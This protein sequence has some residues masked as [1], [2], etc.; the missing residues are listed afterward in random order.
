[1]Y[2]R[3]AFAVAAHLEPDILLVDEVL[4]VGDAAFQEKCLGK[5][6]EVSRGGR[7]VVFV[8]HNMSTVSALCHRA[9]VLQGGEVSFNG[10]TDEAI[11]CYTL[12]SPASTQP[13]VDLRKRTAERYGPRQF[14]SWQSLELLNADG[15]PTTTLQMGEKAVFRLG[16]DIHKPR[17]DFEIGIAI[18]NL[19]GIMLHILC[20][21]WEGLESI[22]ESG[23]HQVEVELTA[24]H[25]FPGEYQVQAAWIAIRGQYY[26]D[27]VHEA[28]RFHVEE[29]RVNDHRTYFGRWSKSTQVYVP[30]IWRAEKL[31]R[32]SWPRTL[33]HEKAL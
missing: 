25:L 8:S 13:R 2:V 26:D 29:G 22:P 7:T 31:S 27:A 5:M 21:C 9:V 15:L 28:L 30:S 1:M 17:E 33:L 4:A 20:S 10:P 19:Q 23:P 18:A 14:A 6:G 3:L 11:R 12:A 24:V 32:E 16:L